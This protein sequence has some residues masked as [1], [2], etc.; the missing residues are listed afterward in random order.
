MTQSVRILVVDDDS[1]ALTVI[2]SILLTE[3][4]RVDT[5]TSPLQALQHLKEEAYDTIL[6]D[7]QMPEM[8]G[9]EFIHR[10]QALTKDVPLILFTAYGAIPHA[11]EAVKEGAY[12]YLTKPLNYDELKVVL[13]NSVAFHLLRE[14]HKKLEQELQRTYRFHELV[15]QSRAMKKIFQQIEL[16]SRLDAPVLILG[17]KGTRKEAVAKAIHENSNRKDAPFVSLECA[18]VASAAIENVLFGLEE[19]GPNGALRV[20]QGKL[21]SAEGGTL[22]VHGIGNFPLKLQGKLLSFL[23]EKKFMRAGGQEKVKSNVRIVTAS[24]GEL[25]SAVEKKTLDKTLYHCLKG[26]IIYI[27][28]LRERREDIPILAERFLKEASEKYQ[29]NIRGFSSSVYARLLS[30]HFSENVAELEVLIERACIVC[31][32]PTIGLED[33]PELLQENESDDEEVLSSFFKEKMKLVGNFEREYF[34]SLLTKT[35]GRIGEAAKI[36]GM[37]ERNIYEKLKKY[38]LKKEDFKGDKNP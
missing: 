21:E 30:H 35:A 15:G 14:S 32:S 8:S 16:L 11:V 3:G 37:A 5:L 9:L 33:M 10:A 7:Y 36:S 17:E 13:R 19:K 25:E 29:K 28:P 18:S 34:T 20:Q 6:V 31:Q 12:H 24:D 38:G 27:P 26:H 2:S 1:D 22:F 4:Y 23:Q